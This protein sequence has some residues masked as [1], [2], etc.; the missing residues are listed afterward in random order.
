MKTFFLKDVKK[1]LNQEYNL[2][3]R[4]YADKKNQLHDTA[5]TQEE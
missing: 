4:N 3:D 1:I 5:G 2:P